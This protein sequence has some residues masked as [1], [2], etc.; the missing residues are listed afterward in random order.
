MNV[1]VGCCSAKEWIVQHIS[2]PKNKLSLITHVSQINMFYDAL[3]TLK[4]GEFKKNIR[5]YKKLREAKAAKQLIQ[6]W[7]SLHISNV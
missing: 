2:D 1:C 3:T 4:N 6:L 7:T 5:E